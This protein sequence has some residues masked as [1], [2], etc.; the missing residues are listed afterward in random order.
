M[1]NQRPAFRLVLL[2]AAG[3]ALSSEIFLSFSV[4]YCLC[5]FAVGGMLLCLWKFPDSAVFFVLLQS[6]VVLFGFA[7][8]VGQA[9]QTRCLR[10]DP[11]SINEGIILYGRVISESAAKDERTQ[12]VF[13]ADSLRTKRSDGV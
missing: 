13:A 11:K 9:D 4:A 12:Y 1:F 10:L 8:H 3:I 7:L 2:F 5:A 6:A